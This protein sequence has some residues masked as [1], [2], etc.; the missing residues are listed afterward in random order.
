MSYEGDYMEFPPDDQPLSEK[1]VAE[2]E[3]A[4]REIRSWVL[5]SDEEWMT[6]ALVDVVVTGKACYHNLPHTLDVQKF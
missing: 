6:E 2:M 4:V 1:E 3:H 5:N